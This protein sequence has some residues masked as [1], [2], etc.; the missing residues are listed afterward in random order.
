VQ[1]ARAPLVELAAPQWPKG[2]STNEMG[3]ALQVFAAETTTQRRSLMAQAQAQARVRLGR[4]TQRS[5]S[6]GRQN[7]FLGC[8]AR[9][10]LHLWRCI[11]AWMGGRSM[12]GTVHKTILLR[13]R[14]HTAHPLKKKKPIPTYLSTSS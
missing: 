11:S 5:A 2:A 6:S 3:A 8:A 4:G 1:I 9:G 10:S 14:L 7:H 12:L 13:S